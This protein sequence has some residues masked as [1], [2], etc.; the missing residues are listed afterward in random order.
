MI[1]LCLEMRC[2]F[3]LPC[4]IFIL[5]HNVL[6]YGCQKNVFLRCKFDLLSANSG[7]HELSFGRLVF[8]FSYMLPCS[9]SNTSIMIFLTLFFLF[10]FFL[11][12]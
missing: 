11:N 8:V 3:I 12:P 4:L 10:F 9:A 7:L 1:F 6:F 2:V 5:I